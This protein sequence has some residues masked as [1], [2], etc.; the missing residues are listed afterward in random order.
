MGSPGIG[1]SIIAYAWTVWHAS[2]C[3][4]RTL[5]VHGVDLNFELL[6]I[7]DGIAT[8]YSLNY[9]HIDDVKY[10]HDVISDLQKENNY[11]LIVCD[12]GNENL[13][14]FLFQQFKNTTIVTVSSFQAFGKMSQ[15]LSVA[16]KKYQH[17]VLSW[18]KQEIVD[19][20]D[21]GNLP[22]P[23]DKL[24]EKMYYA[25]TCIRWLLMSLN[26]VINDIDSKILRVTDYSQLLSG[27]IGD[28]ALTAVNSLSSM[29]ECKKTT[30]L[31]LYIVR[32][33]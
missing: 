2:H 7:I 1:K 10:V 27:N 18:K 24:D 12:G 19:A 9:K 23:L 26:E 6:S 11:D 5:Y 20:I 31:S 17:I 33:V 32:Q 14:K 28:S 15:E 21:A 3:N 13:N 8:R 4:K 22:I 29:V 16:R 30:I 25:G